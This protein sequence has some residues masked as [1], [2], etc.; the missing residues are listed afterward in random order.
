[1]FSFKK[2]VN[3]VGCLYDPAAF[4]RERSCGIIWNE[5]SPLNAMRELGSER[6]EAVWFLSNYQ[7]DGSAEDSFTILPY[8]FND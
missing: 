8:S 2:E 6:H 1:M 4:G 5:S 7:N 3:G